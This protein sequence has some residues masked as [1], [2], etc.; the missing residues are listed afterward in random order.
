MK[1]RTKLRNVLADTG[2]V[3]EVLPA[4]ENSSGSIERVVDARLA[5]AFARVGAA[6]SHATHRWAHG[7][8]ARAAD[9]ERADRRGER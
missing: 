5:G 4:G 9:G 2:S 6:L 3:L 7:Q 1:I 8:A